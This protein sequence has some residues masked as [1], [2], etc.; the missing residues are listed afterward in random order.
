LNK[1]RRLLFSAIPSTYRADRCRWPTRFPVLHPGGISSMVLLRTGIFEGDHLK[2]ATA[3]PVKTQETSTA[4]VREIFKNLESGNGRGF[5]DHVAERG[6]DRR[7]NTSSCLVTITA[8]SSSSHIPLKSWQRFYREVRNCMWNVRSRQTVL[9]D[10]SICKWHDRGAS[11]V[12]RFRLRCWPFR[13]E[14]DLAGIN[15]LRLLGREVPSKSTLE[16]RRSLP[17]R[18]WPL[19]RKRPN[20]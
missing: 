2:M 11:S 13:G 14:A 15:F 16:V 1:R 7:G 3:P 5:F 10:M 20:E 9:L 12:S 8:R 17:R 4:Y 19:Q 18:D 6:L